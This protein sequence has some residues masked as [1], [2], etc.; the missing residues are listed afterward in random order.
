VDGQ[1]VLELPAELTKDDPRIF[2]DVELTSSEPEVVELAVQVPDQDRSRVVVTGSVAGIV[3]KLQAE[4]DELKRATGD[5]ASSKEKIAT[6]ERTLKEVRKIQG[7]VKE[8]AVLDGG[9]K[10]AGIARLRYIEELAD[11]PE[12]D[13]KASA[14]MKLRKRVA[15]LRQTMEATAKE[16][17]AVQAKIRALG[18]DPGDGPIVVW[19]RIPNQSEFKVQ[20]FALGKTVDLPKGQVRTYTVTKPTKVEAKPSDPTKGDAPD[21]KVAVRDRIQLKLD[22][23]KARV[24]EALDAGKL[25]LLEKKLEALQDEVKRLKKGSAPGE[26]KK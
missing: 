10:G 14:V 6:L 16:V 20:T 17:Q 3:K 13:E 26:A 12:D 23:E 15:E 11:Q 21:P 24:A 18:G 7:S 25:E 4:I 1:S 8:L 22:A 19:R 9:V 2:A 5:A